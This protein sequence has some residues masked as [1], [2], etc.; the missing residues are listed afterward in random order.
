MEIKE[1]LNKF[2]RSNK[3]SSIINLINNDQNV[4]LNIK[5]LTGSSKTFV[6]SA[7]FSN[8]KSS[9][10]FIANEKE[11]AAYIYND[12]TSL[13]DEKRVFFFPSSYKRSIRYKQTDTSSIILRTET[14]NKIQSSSQN[15]VMVTYPEAVA[16]KIM[17]KDE[18]NTQKISYE[19]NQEISI[20]EVHETLEAFNF[21]RT[22][23]VYEPG[24]YSI[25]GSIVDIF[26]FSF[27]DP[28]RIDFFGN[29]IDSIRTFNVENQLSKKTINT[30]TLISNISNKEKKSSSIF[31]F[32][33]SESLILSDEISITLK[34]IDE[35]V[36]YFVNT[37]DKE[38]HELFNQIQTKKSLEKNLSL[39]NHINIAQQ[40]YF[41]NCETIY[42]N[43]SPQPSFNK[44]FELLTNNILENKSNQLETFILADSEKQLERLK[45]IFRET[46]DASIF[47]PVVKS[48]AAG[49][50]EHDIQLAIY[51]DHQIFNRYHKYK[52][53]SH[54][55]KKE[56][57]TIKELNSLNPGDYI[58]HI[59][60]GIAKFGGLARLENN[61]KYQESI[62]LV[63]KD[64]DILFVNIHSLHRISKYKG[65]E[66]VP[67]KVY[68]LGTGAWQKLKQTTKKKVKD[69][70]K[71]L[72]EL[73]ASRM[74][75]K[76]FS[77]SQDTYLQNELEASFLYEDTPDQLKSTQ[78]VKA[79]MESNIPMD[80][81]VCGDVGFG[82]TEI[83]IRA[84]F[85]AVSDSKQ[86]AILVPTTILAMQHYQTFK[87]RLSDFPCT[88]EYI[89]R[90]KSQKQQ[91]EAIKNTKEGKV[92]ILIGTHRIVSKDVEFKNL[93]LLIIDEE[94]KFGVSLKEK[95]RQYKKNIDTLTLTATPIP[96]TLQFSL[97]GARDLSII[98]TPPP[99]RHPIITE[100]HT[101]NEE[102]IQEAIYYEIQRNG[103]VFF[104]NNRVQNIEE[105]A[106]LIKRLCPE[107]NVVYAHGKM[108]GPKLEK[109]MIEFIN[110]EY[111][112]L[113]STTIIESGLDIPN[114]NTI[115]IN[116]AHH[117]GLSDLHQLRGRVGRSNKK[118]FCYLLAPPTSTLSTD[119]RRRLKALE[120]FSEL[121]S[122][123][124][125]ALQ[126]LDIRGAG[127]LLGAEQSGFIADIGFDA[128]QKILKEA[129]Q[130]L[131]ETEYKNLDLN[132]QKK[133]IQQ[134]PE[135]HIF[136][137][138]CQIDT[139]LELLFPEDYI[140]NSSERI[141]QYRALD[142]LENEEQI[143]QFKT[144]LI[145]RF[146]EIP[147][148][149]QDLLNVVPLRWVAMKVGVEKI[150]LKNEKLILHFIANQDS[151]FYQSKLFMNIM[152]YCQTQ[153][154]RFKLKESKDKLSLTIN[155]INSIQKAI[156]ILNEIYNHSI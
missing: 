112:V 1:I 143:D 48:I 88:I 55:S 129:M 97:M 81:L 153:G 151:M 127:N 118:A 14:L 34:K 142:N 125:I 96:R 10:V 130:E 63:F 26:S 115:I 70:A 28:V 38:A 59:D 156:E 152:I 110:G 109:I 21:E 141:K 92:D 47:T 117:F 155:S 89:S 114:A 18:F 116:N 57:L 31:N 132:D 80:R 23:F 77:F 134:L 128:Y 104:I 8:Y 94:Q 131:K 56:S 29:E 113:I 68:K 27:R 85:K 120:E 121:G 2:T 147:S 78:D 39:F 50:I 124:N 40:E 42:F 95:L 52:L 5:G 62:K 32:I 86:V 74:A 64:N 99:N 69:I 41:E 139:D 76:G 16:E 103:Q 108:D 123:F 67:P 90:L 15:V 91:K 145:D 138:D 144:D 150:I 119:V 66:G 58:V 30:F 53:D 149:S 35:L 24:Q 65:K 54:F 12:L 61:G 51:T 73:Y 25:R 36:D 126:D 33:H 11:E 46:A 106:D 3:I 60:H 45:S 7:L 146:G 9:I 93:G 100:L 111:D 37:E 72:I 4:N 71:D 79:D 135:G 148:Q 19:A 87:D 83:A 82:K 105:V 6:A 136:V 13:I 133:E 43:T 49:F 17:D 75:Q 20:E 101:F 102:I 137:N 22:D 44:N 98:N 122:G 84:A 154:N 107:V 140:I